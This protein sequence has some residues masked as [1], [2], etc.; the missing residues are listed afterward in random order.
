MTFIVSSVHTGS[1]NGIP[2]GAGVRRCVADNGGP[3][4]CPPQPFWTGVAMAPCLRP[5]SRRWTH[6]PYRFMQVPTNADF[7]S[8]SD[9]GTVLHERTLRL[10][11]ISRFFWPAVF[12]EINMCELLILKLNVFL[13]AS[14]F[15][16]IVWRWIHSL[17]NE[18]ESSLEPQNSKNQNTFPSWFLV[19]KT[20]WRI[21]AGFSKFS[22][23]IF[24]RD[25]RPYRI[26]PKVLAMYIV[27]HVHVLVARLFLTP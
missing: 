16:S 6:S 19:R 14:D 27:Y 22:T 5:F 9:V 3:H 23:E 11:S 25:F 26:Q 1:T 24:D 18:K 20:S 12:G 7:R 13:N 10:Y 4:E 8:L 15:S 21:P 2:G 17:F